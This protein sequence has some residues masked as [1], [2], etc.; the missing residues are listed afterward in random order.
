MHVE[1]EVRRGERHK[2]SEATEK[3][4]CNRCKF[5]GW[6]DFGTTDFISLRAL[7]AEMVHCNVRAMSML[8]MF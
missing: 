6:H 1:K 8:I 3:V 2:E 5:L 4:T 7:A